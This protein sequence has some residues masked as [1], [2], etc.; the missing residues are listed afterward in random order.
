MG[1]SRQPFMVLV[2]CGIQDYLRVSQMVLG[3]DGG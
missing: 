2:L 1:N 3:K